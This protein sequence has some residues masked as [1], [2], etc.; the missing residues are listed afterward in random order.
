M[1]TLASLVCC[2]PGVILR[3]R[4]ETGSPVLN[5]GRLDLLKQVPD[6]GLICSQE[7]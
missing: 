2:L 4:E 7:G 6:Q 5:S 1:S 3:S